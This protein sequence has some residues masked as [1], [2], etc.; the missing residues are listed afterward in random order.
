[1]QR[2]HAIDRNQLG[3]YPSFIRGSREST[4]RIFESRWNDCLTMA[5]QRDAK[6]AR[7]AQLKSAAPYNALVHASTQF[8]SLP[9]Q[10]PNRAC[11]HVQRASLVEHEW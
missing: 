8:A 5:M 6:R 4:I 7:R 9:K 1:M 11:H 3:F 10:L 2:A